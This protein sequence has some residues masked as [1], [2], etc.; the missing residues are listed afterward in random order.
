MEEKVNKGTSEKGEVRNEKEGREKG[1]KGRRRARGRKKR[2]H[3]GKEEEKKGKLLPNFSQ[4]IL[5][6]NVLQC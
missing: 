3:D 6:C 2:I 1:R 5:K 4:G